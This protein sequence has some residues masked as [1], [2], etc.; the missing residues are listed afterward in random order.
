MVA[1][2]LGGHQTADINEPQQRFGV[3]LIQRFLAGTACLELGQLFVW[4]IDQ[5]CKLG[6]GILRHGIAQ[7]L[8]HFFANDTGSGIQNMHKS[9]ILAVQVAHEVLGTLGQ[10]EQ[11]LRTDDLAGCRRLRRII[12]RKQGQ[13]LEII[14]D[15]IGFGAHGLLH[16]NV[17]SAAVRHTN[18]AKMLLSICIIFS[19]SYSIARP[20]R[21]V[22]YWG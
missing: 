10:L 6:A 11:C 21:K 3:P 9:F 17:L 7:H 16:H 8:I 1:G 14:A 20:G 22:V 19:L 2:M 15:L 12:P 13:V 5:R 4:V 18:L